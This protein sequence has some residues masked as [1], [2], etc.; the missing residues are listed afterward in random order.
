MKIFSASADMKLK[1]DSG[2]ARRSG[3]SPEKDD[4]A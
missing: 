3:G 2:G 4:L 1:A